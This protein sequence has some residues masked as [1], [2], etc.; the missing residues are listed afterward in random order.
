MEDDG[1]GSNH[2]LTAEERFAIITCGLEEYNGADAVMDILSEEGRTLKGLWITVS[3]GRPHLGYAVPMIKVADFLQAGVDT[4]LHLPRQLPAP[5]PLVSHRARFYRFVLSALLS[6]IGAP[7]SRLTFKTESE[8]HLSKAGFLD[9]LQL[10]TMT[11]QRQ[12]KETEDESASTS[13]LSPLLTPGVQALDEEYTGVDFDFGGQTRYVLSGRRRGL[14]SFA[15]TFLSRLGY[16]SRSHLM[17]AMLPGLTGEKMSASIPHS[18]IDVLD[19][20]HSISA[21]IAAVTY[22][23][24]D[25]TSRNAV[26]ALV[27]LVV[28]PIS[29]LRWEVLLGKSGTEGWVVRKPFCAEGAPEG[30]LLSVG[31]RNYRGYEEVVRE[32]VDGWLEFGELRGAVASAVEGLVELV[33]ESYERNKEWQECAALAYPDEE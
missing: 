12:V 9:N 4:S 32:L 33:R 23:P 6:A 15:E 17:N 26:L 11:S 10:A 30:T 31:E 28:I 21:K 8:L 1:D 14:F 7:P 16:R 25:D 2:P 24:G 27:R 5:L 19:P 22:T 3:T 29:R 13:M 18:K 20:P